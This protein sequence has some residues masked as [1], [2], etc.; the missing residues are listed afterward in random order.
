MFPRYKPSFYAGFVKEAGWHHPTQAVHTMLL[1][2]PHS[3]FYIIDCV[4]SEQWGTQGKT[5]SRVHRRKH[6]ADAYSEIRMNV[7]W[8]VFASITQWNVLSWKKLAFADDVR[9]ILKVSKLLNLKKLWKKYRGLVLCNYT[10]T[11]APTVTIPR[12]I[13][14]HVLY[15]SERIVFA[16]HCFLIDQQLVAVIEF[17]NSNH[18]QACKVTVPEWSLVRNCW[19]SWPLPT[20]FPS[21]RW[22]ILIVEPRTFLNVKIAMSVIDLS[23][24]CLP[25]VSHRHSEH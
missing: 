11:Y 9:V 19:L 8:I 24:R 4:H 20:V 7:L 14:N 6:W 10:H 16:W 25:F 13:C 23:L 1:Q 12:H 3:T 5:L 2:G 17:R 15:P 18:P 21:T 22:H